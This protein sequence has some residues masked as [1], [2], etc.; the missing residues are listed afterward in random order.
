M[1]DIADPYQAGDSLWHRADPRA[2]LLVV[3][4]FILSLS[5]I[6]IGR[7]AGV[8]LL[9]GLLTAGIFSARLDLRWLLRRSL[10]ALPFVLAALPLPLTT[11]GQPLATVPLLGW[12][13]SLEG[14][15]RLLT[16]LVKSWLSVQAALLLVATTPFYEI[17]WGLRGLQMPRLLVAVVALMYRYLF[18]LADEAARLVRARASRAAL[19]PGRRRPGLLW[20][21]RSAGNMV[22]ALFVRALERSER[23]YAAMLSRGYTGELRVLDPPAWRP[24]DAWLLL[25][26]LFALAGAILLGRLG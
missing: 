13:I 20:Q 8:A 21:A 11:P 18:V 19:L 17:L 15:L 7:W 26:A 25:G 16:I 3:V 10:L 14:T 9:A 5:L 6:P 1:I 4:G 23:V 12:P 2:K 22:G 24:A